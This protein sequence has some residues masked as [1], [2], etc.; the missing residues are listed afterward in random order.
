MSADA[1]PT[2]EEIIVTCPVSRWRGTV[3]RA[4]RRKFP[5]LDPTGAR[6]Y[7]GR[8]HRASDLFSEHDS[9]LAL[10]LSLGSEICLGE[11]LRNTPP[12]LMF[13]LNTY[14]ITEVRVQLS[15]IID[16]REIAARGISLD[17][18]LNDHDYTM[19][20]RLGAAVLATGAEGLLVPSATRL[21]DNL[22][23]FP[24]NLRP[25]SVLEVIASRDPV[26][27]VERP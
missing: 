23:V 6:L 19:S 26:L 7:T 27:F 16:C 17:N 21:G 9:W 10:Y 5:A 13:E 15:E 20:Q 12:E 24:T 22:V 8:F 2:P 18:L 4:H 1:A 11:I 3:W 25:E 14:R